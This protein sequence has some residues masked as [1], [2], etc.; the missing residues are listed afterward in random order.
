LVLTLAE[1][2]WASNATG[3]VM[4]E[5]LAVTVMETVADGDGIVPSFT[6]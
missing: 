5:L 6:V 3:T 2:T 4:V 1:L